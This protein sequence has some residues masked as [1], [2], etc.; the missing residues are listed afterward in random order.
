MNELLVGVE[1]IQVGENA[2]I[3]AGAVS[4][5]KLKMSVFSVLLKTFTQKVEL[6]FTKF[7][8]VNFTKMLKII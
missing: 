5:F 7:K 6:L 1:K 4:S 3:G 2:I 8:F